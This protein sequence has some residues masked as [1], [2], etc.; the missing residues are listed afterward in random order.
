MVQLAYHQAKKDSFHPLG[1]L[2]ARDSSSS[3]SSHARSPDRS[4]WSLS[5][6]P[7]KVTVLDKSVEPWFSDL[8][9][10]P[11]IELGLPRGDAASDRVSSSESA[12]IAKFVSKVLRSH[13]DGQSRKVAIMS[14]DWLRDTHPSTMADSHLT[15]HLYLTPPPTMGA[16]G[17]E[18]ALSLRLYYAAEGAPHRNF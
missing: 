2:V 14:V 11:F 9:K 6:L 17:G 5:T 3:S 10:Y 15:G 1:H 18:E 4:E 16:S 8:E 12:R 7:A 13:K